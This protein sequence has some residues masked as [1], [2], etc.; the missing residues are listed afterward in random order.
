MKK[1][2]I[3][4]LFLSLALIPLPSE[5]P[6]AASSDH[7]WAMYMANPQHTGR[8]QYSGPSSSQIKW[9]FPLGQVQFPAGPS[10]ARDGTIYFLTRNDLYA[11]NQDGTLKWTY[12]IPSS[13]WQGFSFPT[14]LSD[15]KVV[16]AICP[17]GGG[18]FE[19]IVAINPDGTEAWFF[20]K[21][22]GFFFPTVWKDFILVGS[23]DGNCYRL[24]NQ[25][26][27]LSY[28]PTGG[29]IWGSPAVGEDGTF[30]FVSQ[31]RFL[32]AVHP[33]RGI[34]WKYPLEPPGDSF[35]LIESG[36][37]PSIGEDGTI[38]FFD[39]AGVL[40]ALDPQ[41]R[42]KWSKSSV[43]SFHPPVFAPDGTLYVSSIMGVV[44][45]L[46]PNDGSI[47][48]RFQ[49][50]G[51]LRCP[52]AV[53]NQGNLFFGSGD[54]KVYALRPD[55]S[56]LW[57]VETGGEISSFPAFPAIGPDGTLYI[58]DENGDLYAFGTPQPPSLELL[59]PRGGET[60]PLG[61]PL[62]IKWRT[63]NPPQEVYLIRIEVSLNDGPFQV[64]AEGQDTGSVSWTPQETGRAV[65][66]LSLLST[67]M[68]V[69]CQIVSHAVLIG[70]SGGVFSDVPSD[71]WAFPEIRNLVQEGIVN[72]YPDGTFRPENPVTRAEFAKM[73]LLTCDYAPEYPDSPTF[74][75]VPREEWFYPYV[76]GAVKQGLVV[77][78]PDGSFKP[79]GNITIAEVLTVIV[80]A[81]GFPL[82]DPSLKILVPEGDSLRFIDSGDWFFRY[83]G[84][85]EQNGI[86]CFPDYPQITIPGPGAGENSIVKFNH[87]ATR[88][89]TSV[90][91]ARLI[92]YWMMGG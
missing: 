21:E 12:S 40:R 28:V 8:S 84:A 5:G 55:G 19:R 79:Q 83:V 39:L 41:G 60:I 82:Q 17:S 46:D 38:Y 49:T 73:I 52:P 63:S 26:E 48:W 81:G 67:D 1:M 56:L 70:T 18:H 80:R 74:P 90:F 35:I 20:E 25:G 42:E 61:E 13:F 47:K 33:S 15:G 71:Y 36:F 4:F 91:L 75:D 51:E 78:Y 57:S 9:V 66:K 44:Y 69:L 31:D 64:I 6:R 14:V 29:P 76:E 62:E 43:Y 92:S 24:N 87:P 2:L 77:G 34:E 88:A 22:G 10:I 59:Q 32:Y 37:N 54:G 86:I 3:L 72:G 16:F 50:T 7:P 65:I 45:A 23:S 27:V 58:F 89:Q 53:D 11:I 68:E 85:A 30:Y